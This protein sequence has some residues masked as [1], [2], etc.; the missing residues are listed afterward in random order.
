MKENME[1]YLEKRQLQQ[2]SGKSIWTWTSSILY[3]QESWNLWVAIEFAYILLENI[4][5]MLILFNLKCAGL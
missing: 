2:H 4:I 5:I 1:V 3:F